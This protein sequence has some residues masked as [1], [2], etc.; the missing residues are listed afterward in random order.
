MTNKEYILKITDKD[1][2]GRVEKIIACLHKKCELQAIKK[3]NSSTVSKGLVNIIVPAKTQENKIS[4]IAHH[5]VFPGSFGY[6]DNS[7]GVVTL[8]K[9]QDYLK[10]NVE[11]VFTDGEEQ[12]GQGCR[13]YL[14]NSLRPKQAINVD[15]V[16]LGNKIFFEHYGGNFKL[17]L[18]PDLEYFQ[19]IPFSDSYIL[20]DFEVPS[21]LILTG[22][23]KGSLIRDIFNSQHC[24]IYDSKIELISETMMDKVFDMLLEAIKL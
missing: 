11:L 22:A 4:I 9:L 19:G 5:D 1:K 7:T 24:G 14:E 12:G 2:A 18:P 17:P 8:L 15:V 6:N 3:G 16:G 23:S 10:D 13:F 20:R 21:V